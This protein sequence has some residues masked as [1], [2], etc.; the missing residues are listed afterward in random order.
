MN[1]K[2]KNNKTRKNQFFFSKILKNNKKSKKNNNSENNKNK[3]K[4]IIQ[5]SCKYKTIYVKD[6]YK[7]LKRDIVKFFFEML[8]TIKLFHWNT[9]NYGAHK[10]SDEIY[11]KLNE[12]MDKF[13]EVIIGKNERRID[14]NMTKN[15]K[16]NKITDND[17]MKQCIEN[18]IKYLKTLDEKKL[19]VELINIRDDIITDM[20]QFIYLLSLE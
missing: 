1:K 7:D 10:A 5:T 17:K 4:K 15:I 13:L 19:D 6:E 18:F 20:K 14:M 9:D 2:Q 11:E 12:H 3:N 8:F 16:I